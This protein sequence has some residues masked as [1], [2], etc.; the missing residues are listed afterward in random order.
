MADVPDDCLGRRREL[1]VTL[2]LL[3]EKAAIDAIGMR[4][5]EVDG[6][7]TL[8]DVRE[9]LGNPRGSGSRRPANSQRR[10]DGLD[11]FRRQIV[12]IE[13]RLLVRSFPESREVGL[14]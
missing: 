2:A 1:R 14:V 7:A 9:K 10:I 3:I 5:H 6:G 12:Q 4:R 11:R 13:I 8:L